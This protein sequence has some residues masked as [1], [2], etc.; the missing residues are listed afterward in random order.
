MMYK[1]D[2]GVR[3]GIWSSETRPNPER[4]RDLTVLRLSYSRASDK[5][6]FLDS[7]SIVLHFS[8]AVRVNSF[9]R[10]QAL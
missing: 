10:L 9:R 6:L 2:P 3:E 7:V 4:T 1:L 5:L 8:E